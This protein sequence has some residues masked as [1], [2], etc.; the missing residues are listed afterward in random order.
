MNLAAKI[1]YPVSAVVVVGLVALVVV[2]IGPAVDFEPRPTLT[3]VDLDDF[4]EDVQA[5]VTATGLD[6]FRIASTS[7]AGVDA[8][9]ATAVKNW[10]WELPDGIVMPAARNVPDTPGA[11]WDGMGVK[12]AFQKYSTYVTDAVKSGALP[13]AQEDHL[14]D[15]LEDSARTLLAIGL[16][17]DHGYIDRTIAP[18]RAQ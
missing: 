17:T 9:Y 15:E 14:L 11:H 12:A 2:T 5:L 16:L 10:P 7:H 4:P 13:T 1:A 8:E 18:L 3:R 6:D